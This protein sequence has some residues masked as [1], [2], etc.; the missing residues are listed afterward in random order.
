MLIACAIGSKSACGSV[1]KALDMMDTADIVDAADK[2]DTADVAHTVD[3]V[4]LVD[5]AD[6][7]TWWTW[8]SG[9]LGGDF[10]RSGPWMR[11]RVWGYG[12]EFSLENEVFCRFFMWEK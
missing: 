4:E 5:M 2:T 11:P 7:W 6:R 3:A 9:E 10:G 12:S 8:W 1:L